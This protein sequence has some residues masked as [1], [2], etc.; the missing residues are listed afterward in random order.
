MLGPRNRLEWE[1][2]KG[3]LVREHVRA[4]AVIR[5]KGRDDTEGASCFGDADIARDELAN[6]QKHERHR[7]EEKEWDESG[8]RPK[9]RDAVDKPRELSK[10]RLSIFGS[11]MTNSTYSMMNVNMNQT[12][13]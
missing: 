8:I 5:D 12:A 13:R 1:H 4:A 2:E 11:Y 10:I 9:R 7:Q 6:H 3:G